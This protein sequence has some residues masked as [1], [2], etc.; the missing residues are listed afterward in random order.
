M[1]VIYLFAETFVREMT[2]YC[3]ALEIF[4]ESFDRRC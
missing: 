3:A 4:D 2:E 1:N